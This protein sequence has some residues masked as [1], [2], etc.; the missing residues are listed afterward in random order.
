MQTLK[1]LAVLVF[2]GVGIVAY[3]LWGRSGREASIAPAAA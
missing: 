3:A 2:V 1:V